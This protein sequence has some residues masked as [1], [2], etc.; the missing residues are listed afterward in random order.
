M[1]SKKRNVAILG[2]AGRD[3]H[4]FLVYYKDNPA[5][6]VK[7]FTATQI[8]G[9]EKRKFPK[10][11]AGKLYKQ[12]IPIFPEERLTELIRKYKIDEVVYSY[13]DLSHNNVMHKAA[14]AQAAGASFVLLGPNDTMLTS[15]K[16][17]IAVTA[18]R[19]GSGKSQTTRKIA[20][21]LQNAGKRVVAV[22]HPMPYGDLA[23]QRVQRFA[24][25]DDF[26]KHK[27]TIE[28]REEYEPWVEMDIPIY[29]GVDYAAILKEAEKE[30]DIILWD[31]GNNDMSFYKADL[32]VTV[33]DPHRAGHELLYHP[34]ET[35]IRLADVIVINKVETAPPEGVTKVVK[36]IQKVNP[37]ATIIKAAS[38]LV[39]HGGQYM[40][41]K[42]AL[43]IEDGPTLTHGEMSYGAGYIAAKKHGSKIVSPKPYAVGTIKQ[44]YQ[45]FKQV[46]D[47]LP[48]MGYGSAQIKELERTIKRVPCDIV[49]D[50]T[51]VV[52]SR[53][54]DIKKPIVEVDYVLREKGPGLA[55]V[56][57]KRKFM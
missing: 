43:I 23:K 21:L 19:T 14:T 52:L 5:Y 17:V 55:A 9:I 28:E 4:N 35:N 33:A 47:V 24:K 54:I 3:Y 18:V 6:D 16:K 32:Y 57:K 56:L 40:K 42:K 10:S 50:G 46:K 37:N 7:F 2:A 53:L 13:S 30:A 39:I 41:G 31:G 12:D 49:V 48:A 36:H 44:V 8:P 20:Q 45:N 22:R 34:G 29:A 27:C 38:E 51:P 25:Y 15:K 1:A 11:M 26:E